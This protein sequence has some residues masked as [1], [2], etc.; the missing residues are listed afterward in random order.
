MLKKRLVYAKII[1][2]VMYD[3]GSKLG[4]LKANVELGLK[5]K[6]IKDEFKHF[7]KNKI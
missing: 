7:L 2:G 5:D 4:W 6:E 1:E 3:P